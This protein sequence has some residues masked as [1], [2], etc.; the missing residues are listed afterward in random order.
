MAL[1][2]SIREGFIEG[3]H[4]RATGYHLTST[5]GHAYFLPPWTDE[6]NCVGMR[7][8]GEDSFR[9]AARVQLA[10]GADSVKVTS[11]RGLE[12]PGDPRISELTVPEIRAAVE[13]AHKRG[14]L[15]IAHAMGPQPIK[16]AIEAGVD[17]I[18][19]GFWLDE[20]CAEMMAKKGVFWE[21]TI[22][23]PWRIAEDGGKSGTPEFYVKN[24]AGAA[25]A[26]QKN[27]LRW[28]KAGV[29]VTLGSDAGGVPLFFHGENAEELQYMVRLGMRPLDALLAATRVSAECLRLEKVGSLEPGKEADLL[30][31][32][33][34]P[35]EDIGIL[36][37]KD[38]IRAVIKGGRKAV[39]KLPVPA[40]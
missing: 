10:Y 9:K 4:L 28:V 27:F 29:R 2:D 16:N 26:L 8:D 38:K 7:C 21:P 36:A 3:P 40:A 11:G 33:G 25:E 20:E 37:K 31:V 13:E 17:S 6:T 23:Y 19:H 5:G 32:E 22:R 24:C 15:A 34:N 35:L 18:V 30:V 1:R 39:W 14:K 12:E